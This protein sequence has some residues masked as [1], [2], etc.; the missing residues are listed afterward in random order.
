MALPL[1][2]S[3]WAGVVASAI[4]GGL[5]ALSFPNGWWPRLGQAPGWLAWLALVPFL[6]AW[7]TANWPRSFALGWLFGFVYFLIVLSWLRLINKDTHVDN[8]INWVIFCFL[9]GVYFGLFSFSARAVTDRLRWPS[10]LVLPLAWVAW[11]YVRGHIITGGW[12]WASLGHTQYANAWV[13]QVAAVAG[14]GGVSFWVM[15]VGAVLAAAWSWQ[16]S[17]L[18]R[19]TLREVFRRPVLATLV[20]LLIAGWCYLLARCAVEA[21]AFAQQPTAPLRLALLQGNLNTDQRWDETYKQNAFARMEPLHLEAAASRPDLIL[22]AESCFP[23]ILEYEPESAWE[24]RLRRLIRTGATPTLLTSN[25]Y[26]PTYLL[27]GP[28]YHHYNSAFF[29]GAQGETLGRYRKIKLVP[30]GE[31]IPWEWMRRFMQAAV[32]EPIPV[33]FEPGTEVTPL[34][35]NGKRFSPLICYE[36]H[37]EELG[38]VLAKNGARFFPS[39]SND[40]W[41]GRSAMSSQHTAMAVFLAIEHRAYLAKAAMTGPT[42]VIDPWGKLGDPLPYFTPGIKLV[43]IYPADFT[44]FFGRYGNLIPFLLFLAFCFLVAVCFL[45]KRLLAKF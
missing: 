4:A 23:G 29:L 42:L 39:V 26:Q 10:V 14:V 25:E 6:L 15:T 20:L 35:L 30:V 3:F 31:Y 37:F 12:P 38:F 24:E 1:P 13:R 16:G 41:A 40:G 2:R 32:R 22:W 5:L 17:A 9:G 28:R 18:P 44:T 19:L 43:T 7:R 27:E 21:R 11:E 36:D 34:T 33:D 45:P 8:A